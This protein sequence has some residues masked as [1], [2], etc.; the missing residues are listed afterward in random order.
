MFSDLDMLHENVVFLA[1]YL[2]EAVFPPAKLRLDVL[3][4]VAFAPGFGK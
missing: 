3:K 4:P 2:T 1:A